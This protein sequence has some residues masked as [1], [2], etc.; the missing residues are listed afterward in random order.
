MEKLLL[1]IGHDELKDI[2][3]GKEAEYE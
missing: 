2:Y 1:I 3:P